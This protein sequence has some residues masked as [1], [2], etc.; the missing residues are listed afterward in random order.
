MKENETCCFTGH[1]PMK[2]PFGADES[3]PKCNQLKSILRTEI[4]R[5]ITE[6]RVC[7]FITGMALGI[8]Q[9]CAEIVLDLKEKYPQIM[10][11]CAIPYEGQA[12]QWSAEQR[13][14]YFGILEKCDKETMLQTR[15]TKDCMQKRNR[16]MVDQS[17]H[18]LAVWDGSFRS[19]SGQTVRYAQKMGKMI[20]V[21]RPDTLEITREKQ[22]NKASK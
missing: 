8:D 3:H 15:Y 17:N 7:R 5:L 2:L 12:I 10:P 16:Y 1:R 18:V 9:I 22:T 6:H 4:E 20:T 14:R 13:D 11:E 19:G 21:I